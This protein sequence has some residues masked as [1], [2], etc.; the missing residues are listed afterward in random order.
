MTQVWLAACLLFAAPAVLGAEP[1]AGGAA[2]W[3]EVGGA[4]AELV[5]E[6][7]FGGRVMLYRAGRPGAEP[8][9]L[10]HGLGK[11]AAR[12]WAKL[13][14]PLAERYDV[15][16]LDL[17]GFGLSDKG[18]HLYSPAN[19]ARALDALL[20]ERVSRPVALV[21]HSMGGAVA[22]AYAAAYPRSVRRLIVVDAAGVLHRSVYGE[23]LV[24]ALA[25]RSVGVEA[26]W[27][28]LVTRAIQAQAE[29]LPTGSRIALHLPAVRQRLL[30][31]DP[32]AIAALALVEH[33][34]SSA[35]RAIRAPTLVVWGSDDRIAPLR[36]GEAVAGIIPG[37]RLVVIPGAGHAPQLDMPQRFNAIVL[38]ELGGRLDA[39][40]YALPRAA[41]RGGRVGR[42]SGERGA[43]FSGDFEE[44]V[45]RGCAGVEVT[46][47]RIGRLVAAHSEAR[48]VNS[49]V[50][51]GVESN[52][53]RLE[54]T[55]GSLGGDPPLVL[56]STSV[57][58]AGVRFEPKGAV[59]AANRGADTVTLRLSV[60]EIARGNA[61]PRTVHDIVRLV[62]DQSWTPRGARQ[63][64]FSIR[65]APR[66]P[67]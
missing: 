50:R 62:S 7:V 17:P 55:G 20:A 32:A 11:A 12:D 10:V 19:F 22:L 18:N 31:G 67:P 15:Y 60:S 37:A 16:A 66:S 41:L 14:P 42:C 58:A 39:K 1:A 2:D 65:P 51:D 25:E 48:I 5:P 57:D 33:D 53:S 23:F 64:D 52:D 13:I 44:L 61:P 8:V 45:L 40:P 9:V 6:P 24:R 49:Q 29:N 36:T 59:A 47:A 30:R 63:R 28:D 38:D 26:P 4:S 56:D 21:G 46:G 43:Q 35:L 27:L 3:I 34:F 54:F